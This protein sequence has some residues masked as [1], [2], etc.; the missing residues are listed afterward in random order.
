MSPTPTLPE[1]DRD[2][3][4]VITGGAPNGNGWRHVDPD[5]RSNDWHHN[6]NRQGQNAEDSG[7]I[8]N[9]GPAGEADQDMV[10]S[11]QRDFDPF[12]PNVMRRRIPR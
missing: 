1:I 6:L 11:P 2:E 9:L 8:T 5:F 10:H 12:D 7:E 4:L 3:L